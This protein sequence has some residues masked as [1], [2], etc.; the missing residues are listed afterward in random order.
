M[1]REERNGKNDVGQE[2]ARALDVF[3]WGFGLFGLSA[4]LEQVG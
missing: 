4:E 1:F 3:I 2:A